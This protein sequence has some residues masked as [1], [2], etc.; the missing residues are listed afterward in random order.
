MILAVSLIFF[1][2]CFL[3]FARLVGGIC[4]SCFLAVGDI[5][6]VYFA[7]HVMHRYASLLCA[8]RL[9]ETLAEEVWATVTDGEGSNIPPPLRNCKIGDPSTSGTLFTTFL[10]AIGSIRGLETYALGQDPVCVHALGDC[11]SWLAACLFSLG[12]GLAP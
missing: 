11:V 3:P 1:V 4:Q 8:E 5:L 7:G 10:E 12:F 6:W 2:S 9:A